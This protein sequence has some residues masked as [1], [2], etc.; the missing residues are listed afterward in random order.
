MVGRVVT[1]S[2]K[3]VPPTTGLCLWMAA[4]SGQ[5][6]EVQSPLREASGVPGRQ[7]EEDRTHPLGVGKLDVKIRAVTEGCSELRV[8]KREREGCFLPSGMEGREQGLTECQLSHRFCA[9]TWFLA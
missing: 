1:A 3:A 8:M 4:A 5:V 6:M 9:R 7:T 2:E